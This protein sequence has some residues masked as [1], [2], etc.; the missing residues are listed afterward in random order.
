MVS[1]VFHSPLKAGHHQRD[2]ADGAR[3]APPF[4]SPHRCEKPQAPVGKPPRDLRAF[5]LRVLP[6]LLGFACWS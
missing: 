5:W 1:A 3:S 6:P 4:P 2:T